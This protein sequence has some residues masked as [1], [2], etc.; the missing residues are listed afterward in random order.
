M[1]IRE[2]LETHLIA[3]GMFP[4]DVSAV[5]QQ[6]IAADFNDCMKQR[7]DDDVTDYPT[8]LLAGL[9]ASTQQIALQWIDANCPQ[10]W[11]RAAF[12]P[13]TR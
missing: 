2:K 1:R 13:E 10:A 8:A 5:M 4:Q 6:V 9:W 11:Y 7:W 12:T 3:N